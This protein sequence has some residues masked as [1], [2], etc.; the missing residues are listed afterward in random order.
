MDPIGVSV[1]GVLIK[2]S[3]HFIIYKVCLINFQVLWKYLY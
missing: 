3:F 2:Y 1:V